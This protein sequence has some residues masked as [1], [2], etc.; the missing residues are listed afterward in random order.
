M[1]H[2]ITTTLLLVA[3]I[4]LSATAHAYDFEVDGIYYNIINGNQAEVTSVDNNWETQDYTGDVIIPATV[5][6]NGAT[7]SVT[8]IGAAFEYCE[9]LTSVTI[10]N[11]VT[12]IGDCAFISCSGLTSIEIPN[13]VT[14]I[15]IQ[16]FSGCKKLTSVTIPNSVMTIGDNA[17]EEC[18]SLDTLNFCASYCDDF[19]NSPF[20]DLTISIL[21][22]E[23]NVH[24]IP[25]NFVKNLTELKN[26]N[27]PNVS[28]IGSRAFYGCTG[29]TS[30][31]IGIVNSIEIDAFSGCTSLDT[32]NFHD[33]NYYSE[34]YYL[35]GRFSSISTINIYS[36]RIPNLLASGMTGLKNL[37]IYNSV[38]EI[39]E[40]AFD[41]CTGLTSVFLP[42]S[43]TTIGYCAF[44]E[45]TGLTEIIIPNSIK[46]IGDYAFLNCNNLKT[47]YLT[48][49][50]EWTAGELPN[51]ATTLYIDNGITGVKGMKEKPTDVFS[52]SVTPPTCDENSFTDYSGTLHV[53]AASLAAYFTAPYWC[54][55]TNIVGDAVKLDGLSLN[56]DSIDLVVSEMTTLETTIIPAL[57]TSNIITWVSSNPDVATVVNGM[58][59]AISQGECDIFA[60]CLDKKAICHLTVYS[61]RISLDKQEAQ[62][63][64]NH[65]VTITPTSLSNELP[66][67]V[68]TTSDPT[69]S[70]AR[71]MN[72]KVQVVGVS[73]GTAT[74]T[75]SS[76]DGSAKPATCLI[77][78]Y[79]EMGDTNGDGFVN[80]TD[81]T[82]LIDKILGKDEGPF[83]D[84]NADLNG[85]G[86]LNVSDV[87]TLIQLILNI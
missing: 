36:Q 59:T 46:T 12:T 47:I 87:T 77:T 32:L 20:P 53:P 62:M 3:S 75:V 17:F 71:V 41:G 18:T 40:G 50:G 14:T 48:G 15:G 61:D 26:I 55:F 33:N 31:S 35:S 79:T 81:V 27:I 68:V 38:K 7:Y 52:F 11:S 25:A 29:M 84:S 64:P 2:L 86:L 67:L 23:G 72:G 4:L 16:A 43:V 85:D 5:T 58:V 83:K 8:V 49:D 76:A 73:E 63:L 28:Y 9:S 69:V 30:I 82:T 54:N 39:G 42:N 19:N 24:R 56:K 37:N 44:S 80:V 13:S 74:I 57:A 22:I 66:T 10:P 78:V 34:Y 45:C 70:A 65:I 6:H 51:T 60:M 1:K 21:N